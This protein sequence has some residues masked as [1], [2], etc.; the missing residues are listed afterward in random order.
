L[1]VKPGTSTGSARVRIESDVDR[2][3]TVCHSG[4]QLISNAE[5][6]LQLARDSPVILDEPG[7]GDVLARRKCP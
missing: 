4:D 3:E 1:P 7:I 5:I 6:E 2:V